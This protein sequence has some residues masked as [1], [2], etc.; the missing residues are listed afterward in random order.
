LEKDE[1]I[2]NKITILKKLINH[3]HSTAVLASSRKT[4]ANAS[5]LSQIDHN[6]TMVWPVPTDLLQNDLIANKHD[7]NFNTKL[8]STFNEYFLF[9]LMFCCQTMDLLTI[10]T[11]KQNVVI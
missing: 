8:L 4:Q 7:K 9:C 6:L 2:K 11:P 10:Q 3:W 1:K 5:L